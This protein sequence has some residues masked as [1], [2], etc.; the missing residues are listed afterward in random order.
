MSEKKPEKLFGSSPIGDKTRGAV[1]EQEATST[2]GKAAAQTSPSTTTK[3]G[4][5]Q[6]VILLVL[7]LML[8]IIVIDSTIVNIALPSIQRDFQIS[9]KSLEWITSLYALVFG[10]FLLTWGKLGDEFGRKRIFVA[11]ILL[12]IFGSITV[13]ESP[14]LSY[15]LVGRALQGFGAAMASPSTL[16]ILTTTFTGKARGVAFGVWG[17][18]A[19]A[20]APLGLLLGGYFTTYIS[21][22]W[23]FFVNVPIGV[24]ALVGALVV[25]KESRFRDANYTTDYVGVTLITASLASLLFGFIEAQTYGWVTP[26]EPFSIGSYT[27]P[28]TNISVPAVA[29]IVGAVLLAG[30]VFWELRRQRT[31]KVPLFDLSLFQYKGFRYGI[32]T[33]TIV[34]MGEFGVIF[35]LSI[36]FQIVRGLS[37]IDSGITFLPLGIALFITAPMAGI[38]SSRIGPKWII[39]LGMVL[40]ATA[41]FSL[42]QIATINNPIAYFYPILVV[43]G[44]GIGLAV[45]Q[46]TNSVL[47]SVPWQKAGVGSGANG[48]V[49]QVG[50]AFGVAVI[51]AV[52]VA[53]I[54]SIGQA[55]LA[56]SPI[57]PAALKASLSAVFNAG[58]VG[59]AAPSLPAGVA[60]TP[61]GSAIMAIFNDAITQG[62]RWAAITAGIFVSL[63][64]VSSLL[65]PNVRPK[66][67]TSAP[68]KT[69]VKQRRPTPSLSNI[70]IL[71][72]YVAIIGLLTAISEE[73]SSNINMQ[74]WISQNALPLSYLL[75]GFLGPILL[76]LF[77]I[78]Y[79]GWRQF[80]RR[81]T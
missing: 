74:Q 13:G 60:G 19:G 29:F 65:I 21:W 11:G 46:L 26:R 78:V 33:V 16:S 66:S 2:W 79:L 24:V 18:V 52:L 48:T 9:V 38:L 25:I 30:F 55:D 23:A 35:F 31:G 5:R 71:G 56:A 39:T 70:I 6:L 36:Y 59:G 7:S 14:D 68:A 47:T 10:S 72:Q 41:L 63:G 32:L 75:N 73:Y 43:Y 42:S 4:P 67:E 54:A 1:A 28:F 15:M 3:V 62:T 58:L 34:A 49:R 80:F 61:L 17:A 37:A 12:F 76:T 51:G 53:Q 50:S 69:T 40:E 57:I 45:G 64:A 81:R 27:W 20:S 8:A 22:R 77:G 44:A